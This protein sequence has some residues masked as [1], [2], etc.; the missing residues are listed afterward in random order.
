MRISICI[1]TLIF[2][3]GCSKKK[4]LPAAPRVPVR[5][6]SPQPA[7]QTK[8]S[9]SAKP[10]PAPA[11]PPVTRLQLGEVQSNQQQAEAA[12]RYDQ[13]IARSQQVIA[14]TQKRRLTTSQLESLGRIRSF[15]KQAQETRG[16][17]VVL[18]AQL[19]QRAEVLANDLARQL[20]I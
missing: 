11:P 20:G 13:G 18:A 9:P 8:P 16:R 3:V 14:A 5:S 7:S 10:A 2:A 4:T 19:A 17:D 12:K 6:S 15:L 1:L